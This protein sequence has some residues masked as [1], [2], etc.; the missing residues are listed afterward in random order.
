[1]QD[2]PFYNYY[3]TELG[4]WEDFAESHQLNFE[5]RQLSE[6]GLSFV[7][8]GKILTLP[9]SYS[10]EIR[11][12]NASNNIVPVRSR[13][14]GNG[15]IELTDRDQPLFFIYNQPN[16]W[17][18]RK[19][20][21]HHLLGQPTGAY[22]FFSARNVLLSEAESNALNH[23]KVKKLEADREETEIKVYKYLT[24]EELKGLLELYT[25]L[26]EKAS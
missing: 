22:T 15:K 9:F 4:K 19:A 2:N 18:R 5:D 12:N 16:F 13:I 3:A 21:R 11:Y 20:K 6:Y 25:L 17:K 24:P 7:L 23:Y 8:N 1:M 14:L 26:K 10:T